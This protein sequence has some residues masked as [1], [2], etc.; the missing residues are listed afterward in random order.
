MVTSLHVWLF[1][2]TG[3]RIGGQL[4]RNEVLLLTT[5]GRTTHLPRTT[6]L[7]YIE[8]QESFVVV[9]SAG[10]SDNEPAWW[11]NLQSNSSGVAEIR[12]AVVPILA[13]VV[14]EEQKPALWQKLVER[15]PSYDA[16][17]RKTSRVIPLV[18][19]RRVS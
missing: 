5:V 6:P 17:Q 2:R 12:G 15:Y 16:Y 18:R 3:G 4:G 14:P 11:R 8:D 7:F 9:A 13:E 19:L 1:R 10:G